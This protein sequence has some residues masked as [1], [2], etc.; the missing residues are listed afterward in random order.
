MFLAMV[1]QNCG[2]FVYAAKF[3]PKPAKEAMVAPPTL[4]RAGRKLCSPSQHLWIRARNTYAC[5]QSQEK[6]HVLEIGLT[7]RGVEEIGD[8]QSIRLEQNSTVRQGDELL[9]IS[10]EGQKISEADELYHAVWE[11]VEGFTTL[12]SPVS[13]QIHEADTSKPWIDA[14]DY[15]L[16]MTA[17]EKE[18][19]SAFSR[20]VCEDT[21]NKIVRD[22]PPGR[23]AE[24]VQQN[25][26]VSR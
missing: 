14:D 16:S 19:F 1:R 9:R 17:S 4:L 25:Q 13:G 20:L 24:S 23:F 18:V 10:W 6:K 3:L 22:L 2:C 5:S 26:A 21:Y 11:T 12:K 15:L 8:V 7:Q